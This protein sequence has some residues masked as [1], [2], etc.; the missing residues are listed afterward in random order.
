MSPLDIRLETF[1]DVLSTVD[2]GC[3]DATALAGY[4]KMMMMMMV[5]SKCHKTVE[6]PSV[7]PSVPS[8]DNSSGGR[9]VCCW[10][11]AR[12][13]ADIDR[14]LPLVVRHAGRV[15]FG[16]T[17]RRFNIL[18][19]AGYHWH[20]QLQSTGERAPWLPTIYFRYLTLHL[21]KAWRQSLMSDII[22]ILRIPKLSKFRCIK[23]E[24]GVCLSH[25]AYVFRVNLC[26]WQ[27]ISMSFCAH[28]R[29]K[30]WRRHRSA[31]QQANQMYH[32]IC[33]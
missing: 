12:R 25:A 21:Y 32:G 7:R 33:A 3:N 15:Q 4:A 24:K 17:V 2:M 1:G 27:V 11:R 6:C 20:R 31:F 22:R 10:G 26:V 19:T 23:N 18:V 9:R 8:I 5:C 16:P 28:R 13:A 14:Q 29:A 30:C